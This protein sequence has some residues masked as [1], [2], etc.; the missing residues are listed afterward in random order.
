VAAQERVEVRALHAAAEQR[1]DQAGHQRRRLA[2]A[3]KAGGGL[4]GLLTREAEDW[5]RAAPPEADGGLDGAAIEAMIEARAA[6]RR[7]KDFAEADRLRDE[8]AR[9]GIVLEDGPQGTTWRREA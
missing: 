9:Q 1:V 4:I 5:F 6:A 3:L 2:G 8:L 7:N